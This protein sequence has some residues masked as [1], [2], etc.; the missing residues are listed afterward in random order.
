MNSSDWNIRKRLR[1]FG[2]AFIGIVRLFTQPNAIIHA[3]VTVIV[4]VCGYWL[5]LVAWEWCVVALCIAAVLMAEAFNTAI[6]TIA[7]KVSPGY[8]KLIGRAKDLAAGAVLLMVFGAV[9]AGLIIFLPK[10]IALFC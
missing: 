9:A 10:F 3:C 6:E 7:D 4:I 2:Y 1:S 5:K 8:D